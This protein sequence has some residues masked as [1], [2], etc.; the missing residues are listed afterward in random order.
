M[1]KVLIFHPV[2]APYRIDFFNNLY[3]AFNTKIVL[4]YRNLKS[5][6]FD[7]SKIED[8]FKFSPVYLEKFFSL[9]KRTFY[10]GYSKYIKTE[11]P[12]V[13]ITSEYGFGMWVSIF[14]K[15]VFRENYKIITISDDNLKIIKECS[16]GR[17]ISRTIAQ[18][19]IDGIVL[20]NPDAEKWYNNSSKIKTFVFPIIQNEIVIENKLNE[21]EERAKAY[22][23][24]LE[25]VGKKVFLFVGR[26]SPEKNI[27]YLVK[28]FIKVSKQY[29]DLILLLVGDDGNT[30]GAI[31]K[32]IAMLV[33][34]SKTVNI[35]ILGR[36]DGKD[37]FAIYNCGQVLVL[38]SISEA[39]GEGSNEA[40]FAGEY[41]MISKNAGSICLVTEENG[42][43][44]DIDKPYIDF[45]NIIEKIEPITKE[46][47][48]K[49]N[50]MPFLYN[51]LMSSFLQW[52]D[53]F[54]NKK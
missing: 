49:T 34:E 19:F 39:Y 43:V 46:W 38:Q 54:A 17:K 15:L 30:D 29:D 52:I 24:Q 48:I 36:K 7:Y 22:I 1:K 2:I 47:K 25:L 45:S 32:N 40:L 5:Q 6:K 23:N 31:R 4:D 33:E 42:E 28:S 9:R 50:K 26:F 12:D 8:E 53:D 16:V 51:D 35:R 21:S 3:D 10:K 14:H 37:L 27:E 44:I 41:V 13:V 18:K 20:C 11:K